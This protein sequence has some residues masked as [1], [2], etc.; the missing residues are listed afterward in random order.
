METDRRSARLSET[1]A[2]EGQFESFLAALAASPPPYRPPDLASGDVFADRYRVERELG[3][4][5]MGAVYLATDMEL[6]RKVALKLAAGRRAQT[7]LIRLQQEAKVMA[8]LSHP[9]IVTVFEAAAS[10]DDVYI[11]LEFVP[12]GTLRDWMDLGRHSWRDAVAMFLPL[13]ETLASAHA[14]GVI[15]R[16][17]KPQNVLLGLQGEPRI[18]D[19]GLARSVAARE[20]LQ[21]PVLADATTTRTGAVLGTPAYMAPEQALGLTAEQAADQFSF[22]ITLYEAIA[23]KRPFPGKTMAAVLESIESGPPRT[24]PGMPRALAELVRQGLRNDPNTRHASMDSVAAQLANVLHA[25]RRRVRNTALLAGAA[26]AAGVGFWLAP[27][28]MRPCQPDV[29]AAAMTSPWDASTR[30][31]VSQRAGDPTAKKLGSYR[32][33]IAQ[34]RLET[35][36]AH[37]VAQTL[38]DTDFALRSAC[39]DRAE[40][41]L[42]ALVEDVA[43]HGPQ[44]LDPTPLLQD[45][46][47]CE[48]TVVLRRYEGSLA[49]T[50]KFSSTA[51]DNA[52]REGVRLLTLA[53]SQRRRGEGLTEFAIAARSLGREHKLHAIEAEALLLLAADADDPTLA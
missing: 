43:T 33:D 2:S 25:R 9:G 46:T 18:A 39:L 17:F 40:A 28:G 26:I 6:G 44:G 48:D 51:Q 30:E 34:T 3:R 15:H 41:R 50:S 10:G 29:L 11:S 32:S 14:A 27:G 45:I 37:S 8:R 36:R 38:S 12:G 52:N 5:G 19:F 49:S 31:Q 16:D 7:E 23:G 24:A 47:R 42:S 20:T 13:A 4:G 21:A 53:Q 35:C 1:P 22:F